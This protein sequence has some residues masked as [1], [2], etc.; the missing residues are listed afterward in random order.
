VLTK[1]AEFWPLK[2]FFGH[3]FY[4]VSNRFKLDSQKV[5]D[6]F[7]T[8][9]RGKTKMSVKRVFRYKKRSNGATFN[10]RNLCVP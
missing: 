2:Y 10:T 4:D 8:V 7:N 1:I 5:T 9:N 3:I 6:K